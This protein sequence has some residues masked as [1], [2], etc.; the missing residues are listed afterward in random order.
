M[1]VI[2]LSAT[3]FPIKSVRIF[4]SDVAEVTRIFPL[5][6]TQSL[7]GSLA[8]NI[9]NLPLLHRQSGIWASVTIGSDDLLVVDYYHGPSDYKSDPFGHRH[10]TSSDVLRDLQAE[11]T[12]LQD[13]RQLRQQSFAFLSTYMNSLAKGN[14]LAGVAEP[15]QLVTLFDEF[16]DIGKSRS[17]VIAV[18][19]QQIK[20]VKKEIDAEVQRLFLESCALVTKATVI[21]APVSGRTATVAELELKYKV[22]ATWKP[23]YE[24]H[25]TT[26]D[27]VPSSSVVLTYRCQISQSTGEDW[28]DVELA[29]TTAEPYVHSVGVPE[30]KKME[31]KPQGSLWKPDS[32]DSPVKPKNVPFWNTTGYASPF[33]NILSSTQQD[34]RSIFGNTQSAPHQAGATQAPAA[35]NVFGFLQG[36]PTVTTQG[37]FTSTPAQSSAL[38]SQTFSHFPAQSQAASLT[39]APPSQYSSSAQN[40]SSGGSSATENTLG[41]K[42]PTSN[43]QQSQPS[44]SLSASAQPSKLQH[45]RERIVLAELDKAV[46]HTTTAKVFIPSRA[47]GGTHHILMATIPLKASFTRVAV[48]S[49]HS[50][51]FWTC[52]I[53]NTSNYALTPGTIHTYLD[54]KHVSDMDITSIN[55]SQPI[56]CSLGIDPAMATQFNRTIAS[57]PD[58]NGKATK[59]YTITATLNNTH[60]DPVS[61][62]IV[63]TSLPFSAD[64]RI[65]VT[66]QEPGSLADI[67]SGTVR[68]GDGCYA[69]WSTTGNR[70]GKND[71]LFEWV[72][73]SVKPGSQVLKA[74]WHVTAPGSLSF[75][76]S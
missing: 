43:L 60:R 1:N 2:N 67:D 42:Q 19:D 41:S 57:L 68:V 53:S 6:F 3:D 20:D 73:S 28:D 50:H 46:T 23:V 58:F 27:G 17:E 29:V 48:P 21:L 76:E 64:P 16:I 75:T 61:N 24:L 66:L 47:A 37:F 71:G 35:E 22:N 62:V 40:P 55:H 4:S 70:A 72:C 25:V 30:V 31:L 7:N 13:E 32:R 59:T 14:A 39:T 56:Q 8:I 10:E 5:N 44:T 45:Q 33:E 36:Q 51:V 11:F 26:I 12:R 74:V 52:E 49:V 9:S 63:R 38:A 69:R 34:R 54:G 65:T 15:A 18:L